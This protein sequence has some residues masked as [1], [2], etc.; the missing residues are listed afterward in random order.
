VDG[1]RCVVMKALVLPVCLALAACTSSDP[2]TTASD[3]PSPSSTPGVTVTAT[4]PA[5]TTPPTPTPSATALTT[6]LRDGG[7]IYFRLTAL[8]TGKHTVTI[9][10]VQFLTGEAARQAAEEDGEEAY[11]YY[12]E[13]ANPRLRT[14]TLSATATVVVNTLTAEETGSSTKD[15]AI[16]QAKLKGYV[17]NGRAKHALFY[18]T[19]SK[20]VVVAIH[21]QYLS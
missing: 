20:G 14:L 6:D 21:E 7:R 3:S 8:D 15:T 12:V 5:T 16:T 17:A 10:V 2:K 9:D 4:P 18:L 13:N 11:D 19:L 1:L